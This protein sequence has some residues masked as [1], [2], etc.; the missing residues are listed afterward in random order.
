MNNAPI[1]LSLLVLIIAT[2]FFVAMA[3]YEFLFYA[4]TLLVLIGIVY[5][6]NR[7]FALSRLAAWGFLAWMIMH[8]AGGGLSVNGIRLYDVILLPIVGEPYN[9]LKYD[10][11][12]HYFCYVIMTLL[13]FPV[14]RSIL[15]PDANRLIFAVLLVLAASSIGAVNEII[16]FAAVVIFHADGV[17][18]YYNTCIDLIANLLGAVTSTFYLY[19]RKEL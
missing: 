9:V 4:I 5:W 18:G 13:V 6:L 10:Q 3:N 8:M 16:E 19:A 11:F 15:A 2:I 1:A 14:F 12:V 17:G 7:Q